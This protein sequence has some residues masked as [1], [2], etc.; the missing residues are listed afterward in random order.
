MSDNQSGLIPHELAV[1]ERRHYRARI[2]TCFLVSGSIQPELP[3]THVEVLWKFNEYRTFVFP[4]R[5]TEFGYTPPLGVHYH[6][7]PPG[8]F[9]MA[10]V[11][12]EYW[13]ARKQDF[14]ALF[15][16][17]INAF[18]A[19]RASTTLFQLERSGELVRLASSAAERS[20]WG[21]S[22]FG[23]SRSIEDSD[24]FD[25]AKKD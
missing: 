20:H 1:V 12:A 2:R 22:I 5:G 3:Q 7:T 15:V 9:K 10:Q 14:L 18:R 16:P 11:S 8:S 4:V 25:L 13:A 24:P 23:V 21:V 6:V 19:Y 17:E